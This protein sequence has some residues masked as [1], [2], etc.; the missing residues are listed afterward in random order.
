MTALK[1][2]LGIQAV[3]TAIDRKHLVRLQPADHALERIVG[4]KHRFGVLG[5]G[6]ALTA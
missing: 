1:S 2:G 3:L 5:L 6:L 4:L